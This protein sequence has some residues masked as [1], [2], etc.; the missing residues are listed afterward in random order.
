MTKGQ[1]ARIS[2]LDQNFCFEAQTTLAS[3]WTSFEGF[4]TLITAEKRGRPNKNQKKN[5]REHRGEEKKEKKRK[6]KEG[7]KKRGTKE[8]S[9]GL[10]A[11]QVF[12]LHPYFIFH[13]FSDVLNQDY[14]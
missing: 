14:V 8:N 9:T 6:R 12:L 5:G 7:E 3:P 13:V 2:D 1:S 10:S 4:I 11:N